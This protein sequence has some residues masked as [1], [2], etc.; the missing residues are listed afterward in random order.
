MTTVYA[1]YDSSAFEFVQAISGIWGLLALVLL[2]YGRLD[3][4]RRR[5]L[6]VPGLVLLVLTV[7][8]SMWLDTLVPAARHSTPGVVA[9]VILGLIGVLVA[10]A[11][12]V[13]GGF[14]FVRDTL[15][16]MTQVPPSRPRRGRHAKAG[17]G[18][19]PIPARPSWLLVW[20]HG[21]LLLAAGGA[22]LAVSAWLQRLGDG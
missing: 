17:A 21:L 13:Y 8:V 11:L 1:I 14:V 5:L 16:A 15:T 4:P 2:L 10:A 22:L 9:L 3:T 20:R 7:L 6:F 19:P 12:I 18:D